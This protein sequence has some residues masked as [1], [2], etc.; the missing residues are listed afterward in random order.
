[1]NINENRLLLILDVD[2]TLIYAA[3]QSLDRDAD[4]RVG[5]YWVYRRPFVD[6]FL[7]FCQERFRVAVWST[8]GSEY[9]AKVVAELFPEE[10]P[11][12]FVWDR[13]RC[14][15]KVDPERFETYYVK[16]LKKVKRLGFELER[17]LIV[18]DTPQK[19][20]R[21]YGNAVYVSSFHGGRNDTELKKLADYLETFRDVADVRR[22]EKRGWSQE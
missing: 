4:F 19:V 16:D 22:T 15:R 5:K 13:E 12:V 3:E 1:M 17:V 18:E 20:E 2:E 10:F 6:E 9:L 14:V 21:N 11:P 7:R 8:S